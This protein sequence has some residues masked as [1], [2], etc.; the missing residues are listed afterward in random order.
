MV[1]MSTGLQPQVILFVTLV[2]SWSSSDV[3]HGCLKDNAE[4][5]NTIKYQ[6]R[7]T[8]Y[9]VQDDDPACQCYNVKIT[10]EV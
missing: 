5:Q 8:N 6:K 10:Y 3:L 1:L 9:N 4:I 2:P 7:Y